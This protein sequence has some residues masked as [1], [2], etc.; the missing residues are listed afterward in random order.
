M[1]NQEFV[2]RK[3]YFSGQVIY[4]VA[5]VAP[6]SATG[7]DAKRPEKLIASRDLTKRSGI[8]KKLDAERPVDYSLRNIWALK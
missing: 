5:E 8:G 1:K 2:R 6:S 3:G 4:C 7:L